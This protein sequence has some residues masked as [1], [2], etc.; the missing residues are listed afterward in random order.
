MTSPLSDM[1]DPPEPRVLLLCSGSVAT[2]KVPE[3]FVRLR[4]ELRAEVRVVPSSQAALHFLH[5]SEEY[6]PSA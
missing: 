4:E 5:C 1:A 2:V 6:N 3:L